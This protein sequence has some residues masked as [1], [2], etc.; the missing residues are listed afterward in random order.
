MLN[1]EWCHC[2]REPVNT[3]FG[4]EWFYRSVCH[5]EKGMSTAKLSSICFF[6]NTPNCTYRIVKFHLHINFGNNQIVFKLQALYSKTRILMGLF[7]RLQLQFKQNPLEEEN[8]PR[9]RFILSPFKR[10]SIWKN[11]KPSRFVTRSFGQIPI[12]MEILASHF[13]QS[14]S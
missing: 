5:I 4:V 10:H 9:L 6:T 12:W 11:Q 3:I 1:I 7:L 13:K 2:K 14:G 8:I